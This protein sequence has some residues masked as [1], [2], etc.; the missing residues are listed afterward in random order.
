MRYLVDTDWAID[1]LHG[2]RQVVR[3]LEE[4]APAGLGLT[5]ISLAELYEGTFGSRD[6]EARI[7]QDGRSRL[8]LSRSW[9][10]PFRGVSTAGAPEDPILEIRFAKGQESNGVRGPSWFAGPRKLAPVLTRK[11][12]RSVRNRTV[13]PDFG[14]LRRTPDEV[15]HTPACGSSASW[16]SHMDSRVGGVDGSEGVLPSPHGR[17]TFA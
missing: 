14:H 3:R 11:I 12:V 17:V 5:H 9:L 13:R 10:N 1:H 2:R 15:S 6:P 8:S 4:L 16:L 7:R